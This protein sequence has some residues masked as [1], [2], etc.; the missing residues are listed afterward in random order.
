MT[1]TEWIEEHISSATDRATATERM[2][3]VGE[4]ITYLRE[5][6]GGSVYGDERGCELWCSNS[7]VGVMIRA[8]DAQ[9][10]GWSYLV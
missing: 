7:Q 2:E 1:K 4:K 8:Q 9:D 5:E 6:D 10:E 3:C